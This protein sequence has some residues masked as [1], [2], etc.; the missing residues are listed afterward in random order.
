MRNLQ[1]SAGLKRSLA[2][3]HADAILQAFGR[4]GDQPLRLEA[5]AAME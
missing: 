3:A 5:G 2:R 1:R 4:E